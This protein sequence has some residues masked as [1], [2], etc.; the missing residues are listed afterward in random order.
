MRAHLPVSAVVSAIL[1]VI[2]AA[3]TAL[4]GTVTP[5]G[6]VAAAAAGPARPVFL[7]TGQQV[8]TG[9]AGVSVL[10]GPESDRQFQELQ[11]AGRTYILP[12]QAAAFLN[13]GLAPALFAPG[14]LARA[15]SA[16]RLPVRISYYAGRPALPG[17]T[18]TSDRDGTATGYLTAAGARVFGAAL[19]RQFADDSADAAYGRDGMFAG[20][21][22]IALAG[23]RPAPMARPAV[24]Q[25]TLTVRGTTLSGRPDTGGVVTLVDA[26]EASVTYNDVEPF[27]DGTAKFKVPSGHFWVE[28]Y[29]PAVK[30]TR[31]P[32][33]RL[34]VLAQ[35]AVDGNTTVRVAER[36]A[37]SRVQFVTP[38]RAVLYSSIV[39]L[40]YL[41]YHA[42]HG[43]CAES[44]SYITQVLRGPVPQMYVSPMTVRPRVGTLTQVTS[45]Q[46]DS[47][48]GARGVPYQYYL[49]YDARGRIPAQRFVVHPARLATEHAR[50]YAAT[51]SRGYLENYEDFPAQD[52][53]ET[54]VLWPGRFPLALTMYQ[55]AGE[56]LS[57]TDSYI[58][59]AKVLTFNGGQAAAPQ[60][61]RPGQR[62]T[63]HWG[64][65]P[66]HPATAARLGGPDGSPVTASV[67]RAG[68]V[69]ALTLN[70]FG[71]NTQG[72][73]GQYLGSPFKPTGH[74]ELDQGTTVVARGPIPS[75][76]GFVDGS[77]H[78]APA[79][80]RMRL[81]LDATQPAAFSPLST[82][83]ATAWTWWSAR[84]AA[85]ARLPRGWRCG[86]QLSLLARGCAA[87]PLLTLRY[88][89][90]REGLDGAA[91]AGR[92]VI[93][94]TV[95]HLQ[96]AR[97][98]R[99]TR[100]AMW[101][102]FDGG[103][104]WH[105]APVAGRGGHYTAV[106]RAP[107]GAR[108]TLRATAADAA[109]ATIAETIN[110]AYRVR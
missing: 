3:A 11:R 57:W 28:A 105:R 22:S 52:Y 25:H 67:T 99:V 19:D 81:V 89:V 91:P 102:S 14:V 20:R 13:R 80:S 63:D 45:A 51:P 30:G 78:L 56:G 31:S 104:T 71:D 84:T 41:T 55:S 46:L 83:I 38:R 66:L 47:P 82:S 2:L 18:I 33:S 70:A 8:T 44:D 42:P 75:F 49:A 68:N 50:F 54:A 6:A 74:F 26:D 60:V 53:F 95:G 17:V 103:R 77:G 23:G 100:A 87:Q 15:E 69:L 1:A 88:G 108:V 109:G 73:T 86:G 79:R 12:V 85:Q 37:D 27:R 34:V 98:S 64:A 92:Q 90:A 40:V 101:V 4:A 93:A 29:F 16:G 61:F 97:A 94:L 32:G 65:Y 72:H 7:V 76:H 107:A 43:C 110:R 21:V 35:F 48:S 36:A 62:F 39:R 5:G 96:P 106:F 24:P 58:P 10:P 59:W 9:P